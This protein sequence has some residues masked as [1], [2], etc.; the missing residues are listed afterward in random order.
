MQLCEDLQWRRK[1]EAFAWARIQP[2][3]NGVQLTLGV[4]RQVCP[5]GQVLAQQ[6]IRVLI[7][8]ALPGTM[9]V[10]KEDANRQALCQPCMRGYLCPSI[11]G[12]GLAQRS[13]HMPELLG[14]PTIRTFGI[15]SLHFR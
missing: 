14:T 9:R 1:V 8:A 7:G 4:A 6:L 12:Q 10:R 11:I 2:M 3:C 15:H 5:L 13:R